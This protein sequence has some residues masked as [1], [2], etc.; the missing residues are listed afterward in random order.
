MG[1]GGGGGERIAHP[2]GEGGWGIE[3]LQEQEQ[4]SLFVFRPLASFTKN[5]NTLQ[6]Y[7]AQYNF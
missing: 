2:G 1:G 7:A 5:M 3:M 6:I 4:E